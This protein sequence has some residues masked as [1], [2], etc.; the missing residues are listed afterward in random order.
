MVLMYVLKTEMEVWKCGILS[1][2]SSVKQGY[3]FVNS[4]R[5]PDMD[6]RGLE[7]MGGE[8]L[9]LSCGLDPGNP[10]RDYAF[11]VFTATNANIALNKAHIERR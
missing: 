1:I 3:V 9:F 4:R 2:V 6:C 10:C 5:R 8:R 11:D 7:A